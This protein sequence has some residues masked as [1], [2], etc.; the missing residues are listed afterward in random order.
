[1]DVSIAFIL[2]L[3]LAQ[4]CLLWTHLVVDSTITFKD[5]AEKQKKLI[6]ESDR[7]INDPQCLAKV[8]SLAGRTIPQTIDSTQLNKT[9]ETCHQNYGLNTNHQGLVVKRLVFIDEEGGDYSVL[10]VW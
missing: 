5:T 2:V 1:M 10:E 3:I 4:A 7:L 8:D 6:V 9:S